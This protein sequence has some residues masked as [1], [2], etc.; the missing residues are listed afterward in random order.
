MVEAD[1]DFW[2]RRP[3]PL[4]RDATLDAFSAT[5]LGAL[6]RGWDISDACGAR[7][8]KLPAHLSPMSL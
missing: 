7:T 4:Y 8:I 5:A 1:R 2:G 6:D 3:F